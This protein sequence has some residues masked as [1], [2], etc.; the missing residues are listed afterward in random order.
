M[1]LDVSFLNDS[2]ARRLYS[3]YMVCV[4]SQVCGN[5]TVECLEQSWTLDQHNPQEHLMVNK[6]KT[7]M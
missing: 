7:K 4:S 3:T 2:D 1:T 5:K 6:K